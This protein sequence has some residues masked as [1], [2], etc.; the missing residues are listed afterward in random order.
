MKPSESIPIANL[1]LDGGTQP[2]AAL[3]FDAIED[4]TDAMNAGARFPP[5]TVFYDG[6]HYWL[7]DGFHRIKAAYA[8][9]LDAVECEIR[10]GTLEEAQWYS[11]SANKSNGLRR[12]CHDKQRAAESALLHPKC[13]GHSDYAVARH[14]GCS[15]EWVRRIRHDL[16]SSNRLLDEPRRTVKRDGVVYQQDASAIGKKKRK[17]RAKRRNTVPNASP[18]DTAIVNW[19]ERIVVAARQ[20]NECGLTAVDLAQQ[21]TS[22]HN[23]ETIINSLEK[24]SEFLKLCATEARRAETVRSHT[25]HAAGPALKGGHH[26]DHPGDSQAVA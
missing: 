7:A 11:F 10:Q 4:Y 8:A 13:K 19:L 25:E 2:R 3:D 22:G 21:L 1:R 18:G 12:T 16:I 17:A 20:V 6:E 9:G 15:R 5:V 24:A 26:A 23:P 14:V